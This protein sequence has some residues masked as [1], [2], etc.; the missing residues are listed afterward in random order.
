MPVRFIVLTCP[1]I[2]KEVSQTFQQLMNTLL[3][4]DPPVCGEAL[5]GGN[6]FKM[7]TTIK[8]GCDELRRGEVDRLLNFNTALQYQDFFQC[9]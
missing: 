3:H 7:T 5:K 8:K 2:Q 1:M 4:C 6:K 9:D